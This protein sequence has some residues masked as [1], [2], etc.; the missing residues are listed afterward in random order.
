MSLRFLPGALSLIALAS[1]THAARTTAAP[2]PRLVPTTDRTPP[3]VAVTVPGDFPEGVAVDASGTLYTA[4]TTSGAVFAATP[5][6]AVRT[7][8]PANGSII[9]ALGLAVGPDGTVYVADTQNPSFAREG[10]PAGTVKRIAPDGAVTVVLSAK[11]G[12]PLRVP[13]GI[14]FDA[15]GAMYVSDTQTGTIWRVPRGGAPTQFLTGLEGPNG[16]AFDREGRLV[17]TAYFAG[18]VWRVPVAAEGTAGTPERLARD[19]PNADGVAVDSTTGA[20]YVAANE[21][22]V[23]RLD[24][25]RARS[26][27]WRPT[28]VAGG[29]ANAASCVIHRNTLYVTDSQFAALGGRRPKG[30]MVIRAYALGPDRRALRK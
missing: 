23:I 27:A 12:A 29:F 5:G 8:V 7:L 3:P 24:P 2:A 11:T 30:P 22:G 13:N 15:S 25:P 20:I 16:L 9:T 17:Y 6:G 26:A 4:S 10:E 18:E 21:Y 19:I 28:V 1:C 14:A